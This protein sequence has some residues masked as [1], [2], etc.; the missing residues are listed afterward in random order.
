ME[1]R[2]MTSSSAFQKALDRAARIHR[3]ILVM[4]EDKSSFT[5]DN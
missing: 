5:D 4:T 2:E 3:Q 1:Q